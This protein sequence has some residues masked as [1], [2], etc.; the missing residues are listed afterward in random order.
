VRFTSGDLIGAIRA[1]V[2]IPLAFLPVRMDDMLLVDGYVCDPVPVRLARHLGAQM[3]VAVEV[4]GSGIVQLPAGGEASGARRMMEL[5][6]A[7][8]DGAPYERSTAGPDILGAVSEAFEKRVAEPAL[9]T[10]DVVVS[11][12]VHDFGGFEFGR[13]S[14]AIDAGEHAAHAAIERIR[15]KAR[16]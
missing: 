15:R 14:L 9:R 12:E 6:A 8:R 1:S 16:R 3:V 5:R 7:V 2:S 11:P 13:A 10:A 4:S